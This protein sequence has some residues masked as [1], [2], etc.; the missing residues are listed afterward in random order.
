MKV[1]EITLALADFNKACSQK[2]FTFPCPENRHWSLCR[3]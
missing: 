2:V 3:N 1:K